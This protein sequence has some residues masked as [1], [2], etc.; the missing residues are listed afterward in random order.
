MC[1]SFFCALVLCL[2]SVY[3]VVEPFLT[4]FRVFVCVFCGNR[5]STTEDT[6]RNRNTQ[7]KS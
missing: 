3:S 5:F 4:K 7:I 6:E 1:F 2:G